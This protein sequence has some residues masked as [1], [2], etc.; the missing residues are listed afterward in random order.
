MLKPDEDR[1]IEESVEGSHKAVEDDEMR[2]SINVK[3][4]FIE[5]ATAPR[6]QKRS[7]SLNDIALV[8]TESDT[9]LPEASDTSTDAPS[10]SSD[11]EE[12][13]ETP[14]SAETARRGSVYE[15]PYWGPENDLCYPT[16][17]VEEALLPPASLDD[18]QCWPVMP[19]DTSM[20]VDAWGLPCII[21]QVTSNTMPLD[22]WS[23]TRFD[24]SI[25]NSY[26]PETYFAAASQC[27]HTGL[28]FWFHDE[29]LTTI[30]EA[31]EVPKTAVVL[32]N[33]P[34]SYTRSSLLELLEDEGFEGSYDFV[35]VPMDFSS[36]ASLG[37]ALINFVAESDASRCWAVF[38]GFSDWGVPSQNVAEVVWS[39]P[40]QGV[41][42][43]I[44]R[45]RNS[46]VMHE[47]VPDEWKPA[48]FVDGERATFPAPT[49]K[50]KAPQMKSRKALA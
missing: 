17:M 4:T 13:A 18:S 33:L 39:Q 34:S 9:K 2:V 7:R 23:C 46:P 11:A 45:Y 29:G 47:S 31:D 21:D 28:N 3:R 20:S 27:D 36:N 10:V 22:Q 1:P 30:A 40:H 16:P 42:S 41:E 12:P 35:Y 24:G 44:Q 19:V 26:T 43:H 49:K 48:Y 50:I 32:R 37:Y 14:E 25:G 5:F 6:R 38:E 15:S 8:S